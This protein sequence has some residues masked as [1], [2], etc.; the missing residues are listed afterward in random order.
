[1][2]GFVF[3]VNDI[4]SPEEA[5]KFFEE[6]EEP[7][8]ET[9]E[10]EKENEEKDTPAEDGVAAPEKVGVEEETGKDAANPEGDGTSPNLYSSIASALK[11]DGILPEFS[12]EELASVKTPDDFAELFEKAIT[13]RYDER[14][15]RIYEALNNGVAPDAV[16]NH[17]QTLQDRKSVV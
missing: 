15:K 5:E 17:E 1:M 2:E 8:K 4:L 14:T 3:D 16:R 10:P 12:D 11:K 13:A 7:E 6:Q 9:Q